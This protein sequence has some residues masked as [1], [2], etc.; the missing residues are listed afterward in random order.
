M[1]R[2]A[3]IP[4]Q[5]NMYQ[6]LFLLYT[7]RRTFIG[8]FYSTYAVGC[9]EKRFQLYKLIKKI[10]INVTEASEFQINALRDSRD[11]SNCDF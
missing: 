2:D 3:R 9:V 7:A 4:R 6:A 10:V 1:T 5:D 8:C 11:L